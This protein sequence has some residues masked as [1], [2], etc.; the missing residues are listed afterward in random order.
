V[1]PCCKH[2]DRELI[3]VAPN[4]LS[5]SSSSSSSSFDIT[6]TRAV[7]AILCAIS[8]NTKHSNTGKSCTFAAAAAAA[9]RSTCTQTRL[10]LPRRHR[11]GGGGGDS[12]SWRRP[13]RTS[14]AAAAAVERE[15][16][17]RARAWETA[18][19]ECFKRKSKGASL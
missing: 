12:G 10:L 2:A 1:A 17:E 7:Y 18:V 14:N 4:L 6:Q 9:A 8:D 13:A 3:D 19:G 11:D 16:G 15:R 5:S